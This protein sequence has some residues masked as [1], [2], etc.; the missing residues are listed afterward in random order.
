[1]SSMKDL[2]NTKIKFR[3]PFRPFA[4]SILA[5]SSKDFFS[6]SDPGGLLP[7][8]FMLLVEPINMDKQA[9][10]PAVNH[11]GTARLQTVHP[12][13]NARYYDLIERFSESSGVPLLLNTSFNIRGEPIV[14][15]PSDAL[16]T[17]RN[18]GLDSLIMENF[19]IT[20]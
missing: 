17:F 3:E 7:A 1:M 16:E 20:K 10:I 15:S 9:L 2:V 11:M 5:E 4:P 6:L 8:Q 12:D 13:L 14:N 19:F 18:S